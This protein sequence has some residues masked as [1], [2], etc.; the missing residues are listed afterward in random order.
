MHTH[1]THTPFSADLD[2]THSQIYYS[3]SFA[4]YL[5]VKIK[6]Q[7]NQTKTK[8]PSNHPPI[9]LLM[10]EVVLNKVN[11]AKRNKETCVGFGMKM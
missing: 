2:F 6:H 8:K 3:F 9:L 5:L 10:K 1:H 11:K 7:K 4:I